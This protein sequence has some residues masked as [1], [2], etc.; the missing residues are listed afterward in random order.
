MLHLSSADA[1]RQPRRTADT[2]V[3][4]DIVEALRCS[5][6]LA[7]L[8][9]PE[10]LPDAIDEELNLSANLTSIRIENDTIDGK[11]TPIAEPKRRM[12]FSFVE[13]PDA[14]VPQLRAAP[15]T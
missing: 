6:W 5:D 3:E 10:I 12:S 4:K 11:L 1:P 7:R 14:I 15:K 2:E 8:F 9:I 13:M